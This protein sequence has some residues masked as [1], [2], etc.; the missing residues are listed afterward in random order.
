MSNE[1]V[2]ITGG[3]SGIGRGIALEY[4]KRGAAV[5]VS[6]RRVDRLEAVAAE[7]DAAGGRGL[8]VP[9]DVTDERQ[10][11]AAVAAVVEAFGRLDVALANAG[12]GVGGRMETLTGDDWRR[13]MAVNVVGVGITV[14][15]ALPELRRSGG[16]LG[17]VG[18]VAGFL[19]APGSGAYSASKFAVRQPAPWRLARRAQGGANIAVTSPSRAAP[20]ARVNR[21]SGL[22]GSSCASERRLASA[23][24]RVEAGATACRTR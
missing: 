17:L 3:G 13:Q 14:S 21:G 7:I 23:A 12:F 20:S 4:A 18:S 15:A 2:W 11:E 6:G 19:A 10:V 1:V 22:G 16:R 5:A 8:A 24:S 9:C